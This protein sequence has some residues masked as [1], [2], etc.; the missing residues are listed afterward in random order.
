VSRGPRL[1]DVLRHRQFRLLFIGVTVSRVGD[2]MTFV[3]TSWLAL[4]LGGPR[5]VGIVVFIGGCVAP[6]TSPFIGYLMDRLGLRIMLLIDNA[7]RGA[8]M[9]GLALLVHSGGVQL[10][11]LVLFAVLSA[12]L[13]PATELAQNVAVPEL[14]GSAEL[15]AANRLLAATWDLS[16]WIGPAIAGF[17]ID[18]IGSA[19]ML[20]VDAAT[21]FVMAVVALA[22]PGRVEASDTEGRPA[23]AGSALGRLF[24]GFVLLWRLRPV[25][26]LTVVAAADLFLGGMMEVFLPSFNRITLHDG[27]GAYGLLVSIAGVACLVGTVGLSPLLTRMGYGPGLVT[28]L[29]VRGILVAPLAFVGSW[30]VAAAFV[31]LAAVPDGCFFPIARTV[32][33]RLIPPGFRGRVQ[34]ARGLLGVAGFPLGSAIGGVL[35]P[36]LGAH[37]TAAVMAVGYLPLALAVLLSP[38]LMRAAAPPQTVASGEAPDEDAELVVEDATTAPPGMNEGVHADAAAN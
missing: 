8:L 13:S 18:L 10:W 11:Q 27:A 26:I 14:L 1:I 31:A 35:F 7:T 28:S 21:F 36:L 16:A 30:G 29:I 22:M 20:F 24:S 34:G 9:I 19:P 23:E 4:S 5:A 32:Q 25:A 33:Q 38:P 3:V 2:A 17:G 6:L 37:G 12:V 15:D